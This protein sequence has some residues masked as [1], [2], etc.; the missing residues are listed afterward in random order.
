MVWMSG[1]ESR[2]QCPLNGS[3]RKQRYRNKEDPYKR[4]RGAPDQRGE[5]S[6][7]RQKDTPESTDQWSP[8]S[9]PEGCECDKQAQDS[10]LD[11]CHGLDFLADRVSAT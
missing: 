10:A 6:R 4:H 2:T 11:L 7:D 5:A 3:C 1:H 9:V 8:L